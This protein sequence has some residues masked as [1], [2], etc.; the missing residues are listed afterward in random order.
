MLVAEG[1]IQEARDLVGPLLRQSQLHITEFRA[2]AQMQMDMA[3]AEKQTEAARSWLEMWR[4]VEPDNPEVHEWKV[5]ID[6]PGLL[7]GLQN[8]LGRSRDG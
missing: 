6:G 2:L 3:L 5:R 7:K 4:Q 1:Q 8:L